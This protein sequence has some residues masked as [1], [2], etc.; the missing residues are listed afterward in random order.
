M[1]N[2]QGKIQLEQ[3]LATVDAHAS[4]VCAENV[5]ALTNAPLRGRTREQHL[6]YHEEQLKSASAV[7][8]WCW[9]QR[10]LIDQS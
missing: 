7:Q 2:K 5:V 6:A 3:A 8:A 4:R 1:N 9:V 10:M